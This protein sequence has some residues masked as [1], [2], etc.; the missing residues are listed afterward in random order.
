MR[1]AGAVHRG[2]GDRPRRHTGDSRLAA[3]DSRAANSVHAGNVLVPGGARRLRARPRPGHRIPAHVVVLPDA[4]LLSGNTNAVGRYADSFEK[5][6]ILARTNVSGNFSGGAEPRN[7]HT[8][9]IL[10]PSIVSLLRRLRLVLHAEA[11]LRGY[12]LTES[13]I[14]RLEFLQNLRSRGVPVHAQYP[15]RSPVSD[16]PTRN[17]ATIAPNQNLVS[18]GLKREDLLTV[19]IE[20][21]KTDTARYADFI[22]PST[23]QVV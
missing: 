14:Q 23:T 3:A 15:Q 11:I 21:F 20:H 9:Q 4:D 10:G 2:P 13:L 1:D 19:V 22:V 16:T 7:A 17:P 18:Q 6:D 5:P 12:S 8:A